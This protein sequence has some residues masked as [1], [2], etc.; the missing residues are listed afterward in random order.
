M[1]DTTA[2][3]AASPPITPA[4]LASDPD[5]AYDNDTTIF[6]AW[7]AATDTGGS[8]IASYTLHRFDVAACGGTSADTTGLSAATLSQSYAAAV[9]GTTYSFKITAY[10]NAGNG[11]LSSCSSDITVDTTA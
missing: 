5:A 2:P 4:D 9:D 7:A 3:V 6:F 11:T 8:G 1:V 10:D